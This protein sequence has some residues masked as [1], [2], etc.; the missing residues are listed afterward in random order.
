MI[1]LP[2]LCVMKLIA[3]GEKPDQ[4]QKDWDDFVLVLTNYGDIAGEQL[5]EGEYDDLITDN[6]E[7]PLASARMLGRHLREIVNKNHGLQERIIQT[8]QNKFQGFS[9]REIEHMFLVNRNADQQVI[10]LKLISEVLI[11]IRDTSD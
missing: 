3:Y 10:L 4:R 7:F 8:L 1:T 11:G 6:F 2:G 5:F 9:S